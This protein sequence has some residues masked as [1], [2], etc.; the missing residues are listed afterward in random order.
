M[1]AIP[2]IIALSL[3][4]NAALAFKWWQSRPTKAAPA[5]PVP[6]IQSAAKP[7]SKARASEPEMVTSVTGTAK[8]TSSTKP[9]WAQF[10]SDDDLKGSIQRLRAV[11]CP[12]ETIQDLMV[13]AVTRRFADRRKA[14]L[15]GMSSSNEAEYW[16]AS[17]YNSPEARE[18]QK[19]YRELEREASA[20]LVELLGFDPQKKQREESGYFDYYERQV[21]FVAPEKREQLRRY[22]EE[23]GEKEQ[24]HYRRNRGLHDAQERAERKELQEE[25]K[26]GLAAFLTPEEVRQWELRSSQMA[27][28]LQSEIT[29]MSLTQAQ[30]EA[31]FAVRSKVGDAIFFWSDMTEDP[32][33]RER[34]EQAKQQLQ[35]DIKATLGEELAKEWEL[36]RN[37]DYQQLFRLAKTENL[38]ADT[39]RKVYGYKEQAEAKAKEVRT[40]TDLSREQQ[41]QTL[42]ALRTETENAMKATL[43][44]KLYNT[45]KSRAYWLNSISYTPPVR[46]SPT[47][48]RQP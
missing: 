37:F 12:E 39:A 30:Y 31:L 8:P 43:G 15:A 41:Q 32:K 4:A 1:K 40:M 28:Q 6:A 17:D 7:A 11:G 21:S 42:A 29:T 23:F 19:K 44:D 14:A 27:S 20:L 13:A 2:L 26:R 10:F 46:P 45:Y 25:K 5:A 38:P 22:L 34:T 24:E 16:K 3:L 36:G 35:N 9:I 33:A 47:V 48:S 18:R